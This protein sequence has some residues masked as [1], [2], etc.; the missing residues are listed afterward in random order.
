MKVSLTN[1]VFWEQRVHLVTLFRRRLLFQTKFDALI[2]LRANT[3]QIQP[4]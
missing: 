1:V 2:T 3:P 4:S